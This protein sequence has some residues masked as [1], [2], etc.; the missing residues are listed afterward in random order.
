MKSVERFN[1]APIKY[2]FVDNASQPKVVERL[3]SVFKQLFIN[4]YVEIGDDFKIEK[5]LSRFT[6]LKSLT[7]S[8]YASGNNKGLR[9]A[10]QDGE[11][12][13]IIILNNDILFIEDII[14]PL[15][16]K[17]DSLED[18]AIISPLLLKKNGKEIDYNCARCCLSVTDLIKLNFIMPFVWIFKLKNPKILQNQYILIKEN[19]NNNAIIPIE[20]PSGSCMLFKKELIHSIDGFDEH[21]FLY[22][23]ENILF[24]KINA[25]GKQS[26]LSPVNKCIHLGAQTTT[27]SGSF[28]TLKE[29][30]KSQ[31]YFVTQYLHPNFISK[32]I[33]YISYFNILAYNLT[34]DFILKLFNWK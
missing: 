29:G 30:M 7:N 19:I 13:R 34:R 18:C 1:T 28:F 9:L 26:Y 12:D 5:P 25:L 33:Y 32:M 24:E 27:S 23:E 10:Y 14:S 22:Y 20:L 11:I 6:F 4:E 3:T 8:G 17:M 21:T 31:K 15:I 16:Q 2:I